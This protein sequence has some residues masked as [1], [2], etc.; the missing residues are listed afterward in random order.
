MFSKI[1]SWSLK[2]KIIVGAIAFVVICVIVGMS[3]D[4]DGESSSGGKGKN[5]IKYLQQIND[6]VARDWIFVIENYGINAVEDGVTITQVAVKSNNADLVAA[7]IKDKADVNRNMPLYS[8]IS[9]GYF[10]IAKMLLDA[11]ALARTV[12]A[13][14][15]ALDAL[16]SLIERG[17]EEKMLEMEKALLPHY[18]GTDWLDNSK[19]ESTYASDTVSAC[20]NSGAYN[21]EFLKNMFDAGYKPS[22]GDIYAIIEA[23]EHWYKGQKTDEDKKLAKTSIEMLKGTLKQN[24]CKEL[25][26]SGLFYTCRD[27]RSDTEFANDIYIPLIDFLLSEGYD[28]YKG[29]GNP[30]GILD[31]FDYDISNAQNYK[32]SRDYEMGYM[33]ESQI[34]SCENYIK[35]LT[36]TRAQ[37]KA[38]FAKHG[39]TVN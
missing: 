27:T 6:E 20:L 25:L 22:R 32:Y 4:D 26:G 23:T 7:C 29:N 3:S 16:E 31:W 14:G 28:P 38:T 30:Q 39:I 2:K 1:K 13:N 34:Q 24:E 35:D 33:S 10:D 21:F 37:I 9:L 11:G 15:R 19:S 17:G 5:T 12:N 36:N 18:K 8:A